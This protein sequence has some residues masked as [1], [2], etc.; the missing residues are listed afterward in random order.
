MTTGNEVHGYFILALYAQAMDGDVMIASMW[1]GGVAHSESEVRTGILWRI[2]GGREDVQDAEIRIGC[3]MD[4]FLADG[5][6]LRNN[7]RTYRGAHCVFQQ[8]GQLIRCGIQQSGHAFSR[9]EK[10]NQYT[11]IGIAFDLVKEHGWT[12][13][14]WP[15]DSTVCSY[16]AVHP[17]QLRTWVN[18]FIGFDKL[19]IKI[20]QYGKCTSQVS[21]FLYLR[22]Y[23]FLS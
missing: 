14:G 21:H 2:R 13:T 10:A 3:Q 19:I 8:K 7:D 15:H 16:V 5:I 22:H 23:V 4:H 9:G 18:G 12:D 6:L 17:R 11:H 20:A 1:V